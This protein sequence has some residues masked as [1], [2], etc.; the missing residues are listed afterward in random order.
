MLFSRGPDELWAFCL[1]TG[2]H[3]DGILDESRRYFE[4]TY[5]AAS[6]RV[7][8]GSEPFD[9]EPG[10]WKSLSSGMYLVAKRT[11]H[12]VELTVAKIPLPTALEIR[13]PPS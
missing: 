2:D 4:M 3:G 1:W 13:P 5:Q 12:K 6:H 8:V 11:E 9:R 10:V 7:V